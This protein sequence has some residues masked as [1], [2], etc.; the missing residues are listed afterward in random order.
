[1]SFL[2]ATVSG[3]IMLTLQWMGESSWRKV[4]MFH[5]Y[6]RVGKVMIIRNTPES[7]VI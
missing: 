3:E 4:R 2:I 6:N 5:P 1:M 7:L